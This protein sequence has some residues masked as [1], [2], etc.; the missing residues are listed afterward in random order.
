MNGKLRLTVI[1]SALAVAGAA[2]GTGE[3]AATPSRTTPPATGSPAYAPSIDP[4]AFTATIDNPYLPL[5]PGSRWVYRGVAGREREVD[6]VLVT[7]RTRV[8]MGVTCVVVRDAVTVNGELA[9]LTFDW[10]A[11][12]ADGNVWY[13]GED[14]REYEDG[15]VVS[16]EG[17]WEGGVDGAQPGILMLAAPEVGASYRQEYYPGQAEDMAK[18][19]R[20]GATVTVPFGSFDGVLVT[21]DSTPLEPKLLERKYYAPGVGV[22]L[23]RSLKGPREVV[24]LVSF[25]AP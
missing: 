16:T 7:D 17:S 1:A 18:V 25:Q 10:Y 15:K 9:E 11:Q 23:E 21:E 2:C 24:R 4:A 6:T 12:D 3:P 8:I 5:L 14:S 19:V 22:V 20:L 13:F